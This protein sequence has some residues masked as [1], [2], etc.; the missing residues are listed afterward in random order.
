MGKE[1]LHIF[2]V[3]CS[4]SWGGMEMVAVQLANKLKSE[5]MRISFLAA[6]GSMSESMLRNFPI[7]LLTKSSHGYIDPRRI[8]MVHQ[9]IQK[10]DVDLVHTHFSKD[11]WFL[12]PALSGNNTHVPLV[13]TKH[14]GTMKSK[15]DLLHRFIYRRVDAVVSISKL[16][17]WNV[18]QT[19]PVQ[20]DKVKYIPNGVDLDVYDGHKT[21]REQIRRSFSIPSDA[22]VVGI[23]GRLQWWKG[24]REFI[25]M[26]ER[27]IR[28][29][30]DVWFLAV[31]GATVG[32]EKEAE[33]IQNYARSLHLNGRF[34]FSGFQ[35]D[36]KP[37]LAAMDLFVYPAYAEAFGLVLVEAMAMALPVVSTH[38]DG[39]P[40]IVVDG[41]TGKL[42]LPRNTEVLT[43]AVVELLNSPHKMK[44]LG[45]AGRIRAVN[46]F[47]WHRIVSETLLLYHH[48]IEKRRTL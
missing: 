11:L 32:E 38:C 44:A 39:V 6:Q 7:T 47:N 30:S 13:L 1:A 48:L 45:R 19:H 46:V 4:Q 2:Q 17:Q 33:D 35:K 43:T 22:L 27:L 15:K 16:I 25:Q 9:W 34:I 36:V 18:I 26:A 40:E 20:A 24:Y 42:V 8:K 10:E 41:E 14:V 12:V 23:V 29:R 3:C 31:G 28:T 21:G 37:F 5:G